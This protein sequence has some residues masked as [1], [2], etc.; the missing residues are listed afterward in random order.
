MQK[1]RDH[2]VAEATAPRGGLPAQRVQRR[3]SCSIQRIRVCSVLEQKRDGRGTTT[4]RSI[5]KG[6]LLHVTTKHIALAILRPRAIA[7]KHVHHGEPSIALCRTHLQCNMQWSKP[8]TLVV[9]VSGAKIEQE[10]QGSQ[11]LPLDSL[12]H[13]MRTSAGVRASQCQLQQGRRALRQSR[14]DVLVHGAEE[15]LRTR[16]RCR[17]VAPRR[18]R[19][20]HHVPA[21]IPHP[22]TW[23]RRIGGV[24]LRDR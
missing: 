10:L 19:G 24:H 17:Q 5:M 12:V 4:S 7:Q 13:A 22:R 20:A 18:L 15:E 9:N 21:A 3:V 16:R 6:T 2:V 14:L 1:L 11:V 23:C 8:T